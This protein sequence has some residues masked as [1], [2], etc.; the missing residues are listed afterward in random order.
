MRVVVLT[1]DTMGLVRQ[2][3]QRLGLVS[4]LRPGLGW[5]GGGG[6]ASL[7]PGEVQHDEEPYKCPQGKLIGKQR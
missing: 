4:T 1:E 3:V 5:R 2:S 7:G 6:H